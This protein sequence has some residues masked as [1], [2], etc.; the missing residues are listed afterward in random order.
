MGSFSAL[1][2]TFNRLIPRPYP[3][4]FYIDSSNERTKITDGNI[5][6]KSYFR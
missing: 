6:L 3:K 2:N 1:L 4:M 5:Y